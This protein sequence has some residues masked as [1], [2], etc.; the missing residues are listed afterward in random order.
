MPVPSDAVVSVPFAVLVVEDDDLVRDS[1][2]EL[3]GELAVP[4][5]EA[6]DGPTGIA[7]LQAHPEIAIAVTDMMMPG[8]DGLAFAALARTG[9]PGLKVV[10]LSGARHPPPGETFLAKPFSPAALLT[11]IQRLLRSTCKDASQP[12]WKSV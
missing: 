7:Q 11:M 12:G 1:L 10:F 5:F 6:I 9:F 3:L 2:I 4:V 8:M